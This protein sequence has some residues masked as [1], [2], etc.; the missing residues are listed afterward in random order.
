[1]KWG[2]RGKKV[3]NITIGSNQFIDT[4]G[5]IVYVKDGK[6]KELFKYELRSLDSKP[7][8]DVEIRDEDGKLLGKVHKSTSFVFTHPDFEAVEE[9]DGKEIKRLALVRKVDKLVFFELIVH[10]P[11][12][13]EIN[14]IF[15]I[16]NLP[17]VATRE[18]LTIGN[19][20]TLSNGT[21]K[22]CGKGIM[23]S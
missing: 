22:N 11:T 7:L 8:V 12:N 4:N 5:I 13:I 23:L 15:H 6:E 14:G 21:A 2:S 19:G 16:G 1:M 10:K 3:V 9:R 17:I 18:G 20:V